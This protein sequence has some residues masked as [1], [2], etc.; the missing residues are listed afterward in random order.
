MAQKVK[1]IIEEALNLPSNSR[2]Y[3]AEVLLESLDYEEEFWADDAWR[4]EIER[5]C[6]EI[7][8]G[9]VKL[10]AGDDAMAGLCERFS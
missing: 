9:E 2:A 7:D 8:A 4:A 6:R 5:R 10:V 1:D 3:V